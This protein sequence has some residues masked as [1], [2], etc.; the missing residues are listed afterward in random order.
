M[1]K[2][3]TIRDVASEAG[4]SVAVVSRVINEGTG[5]V[6]PATRER[7]LQTIESLGFRPRAAAR[8]LV[9]GPATVG[10]VVTDL[11]NPFFARLVDRIVWEARSSGS[12]IVLMTTQE[13][14]QLEREILD[15]LQDRSVAAVIATPTGAN[16]DKWT[17][18]R[19]LGVHLTFVDRWIEGLGFDHVGIDNVDSARVATEHLLRQGHRRIGLIS[20]P[21]TTS[22]GRERAEGYRAALTAFD[23]PVAPELVLGV[24]FR[25]DAGSDAVGMLLSLPEPP[26]ALVVA[27]TAQVRN[28]LRRLRDAGVSIPDDLSVI[29]FDDNPWTEVMT[30]PL[31]VVRPPVDMLAVHALE[32]ALSRLRGTATQDPRTIS[33]DAEFVPRGSSA[34]PVPPTLRIVD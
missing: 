30:P 27:N 20:G 29:V 2:P 22:T 7:V 19:E 9:T 12:Q 18:L 14:A 6:A 13:D 8:S 31:S 33:V 24:S 28:A 17:R 10:L 23:V 26:T 11:Q 34:P 32:M 5:P 15:R 1:L 16:A 21:M 4:V 25:G 3:P